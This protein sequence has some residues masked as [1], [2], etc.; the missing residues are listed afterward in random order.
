MTNGEIPMVS[1]LA[2]R[3]RS[4]SNDNLTFEPRL[5]V[6]GLEEWPSCL[7]V[8][9]V[10]AC[11]KQT[12]ASQFGSVRSN[13]RPIPRLPRCVKGSQLGKSRLIGRRT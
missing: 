6:R 8:R 10:K 2:L 13:V 4:G 1:G 9:V 7:Q 3:T 5:T 11:S 12:Y